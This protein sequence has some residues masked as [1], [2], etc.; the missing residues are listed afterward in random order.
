MDNDGKDA[1][2]SPIPVVHAAL[3]GLC[4]RCAAPG[5]FGGI[6][7]FAPA[8]RT[9][10][11]DFGSFNVGDGPAAFL[12]MIVGGIV[13]AAAVV[14]QLSVQP[15]FWV[16]ML[17]WIPISAILVLGLLRLAKAMLLIT[18]YRRKAREGQRAD[19]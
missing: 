17:L 3:L 8:C 12:I 15:P 1:G 9:C 11:L 18:E 4:P 19:D 6:V 14:L 13:V 7:R 5:L 2:K 10:S 16:H